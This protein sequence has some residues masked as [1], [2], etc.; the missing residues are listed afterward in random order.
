MI[1]EREITDELLGSITIKVNTRARHIIL[2]TRAEGIFITI[3]PGVTSKEIK[4][5]LDKYRERLKRDKQK[6]ENKQINLNY[7]IDTELFKLSLTN[8]TH[9]QFLAHSELGKLEIICPPT[10]NFE[11]EDLQKWLRK[12]IEEGLRRNAKALLPI[13]LQA[14]SRQWKLPYEQ[15]RI[16]SSKGRWGSC[17]A[18]RHINLSFYLL[19]LPSHLVDYVLLHELSH[20]K[21]MNHGEHFWELLNNLTDGK[22]LA[23]RQELK[24][25]RTEL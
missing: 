17:S 18:Q 15:V 25:Y 23:L 14:L 10:A 3:P 16:N 21:E 6:F 2:R 5:V 22:A 1:K 4:N 19:L 20:T 24:K 13:R 12:V 8:G 11:D 9:P 7:K